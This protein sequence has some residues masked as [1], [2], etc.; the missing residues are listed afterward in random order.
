VHSVFPL[1]SENFP[2][3]Q[4]VHPP[5]LFDWPAS[6]PCIPGGQGVHAESEG[7]ASEVVLW[8]N[9]SQKG[10][11]WRC[12][13]L[14]KRTSPQRQE[15][16]VP[17]SHG[18]QASDCSDLPRTTPIFLGQHAVQS[19]LEGVLWRA[20]LCDLCVKVADDFVCCL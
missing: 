1:D 3:G 8:R 9:I 18:V 15:E 12:P 16:N 13:G 17:G 20:L 14:E 19:P 2:A 7:V 10:T 6:A 4:N 5:S 11:Q